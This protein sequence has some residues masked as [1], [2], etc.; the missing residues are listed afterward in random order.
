MS[1]T[2]IDGNRI[3]DQAIE[4]R[5]LKA[6]LGIPETQLKLNFPTHNHENKS[7]LDI[8]INTSPTLVKQMDL[9]DIMLAILQISDARQEGLTLK[10]T[11]ALKANESDLSTVVSEIKD[12]RGNRASLSEAI[13]S[14]LSSVDTK[15]SEHAGAI[16]HK[17]LDEIYAEVV[18]ARGD[19]LNLN[20]RLDSMQASI[21]NSSSSTGTGGNVNLQ[22]LTPWN[23]LIT[24]TEGETSVTV[25]NPYEVGGNS[26]QVFDGPILLVPGSDKDY[27]EASNTSITLNYNPEAGSILRLV[28]SNSGSLFQWVYRIKS[29]EGQTAIN[30]Q[31]SYKTNNDELMVYEDGLLLQNTLDYVETHENQITMN[32]PLL[33]NS[34]ITI[35]KRRF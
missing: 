18:N 25:P 3:A 34:I 19:H 4:A 9:K 6:G 13:S 35:C 21:N 5:H 14:V 16:S 28:G 27:V 24:L 12:A 23:A 20:D 10:D 22:A 30:L 32:Y 11:L 29:E 31:A 26:L 7:V 17:Q 8:I 2:Q 33:E 15:I 1:K